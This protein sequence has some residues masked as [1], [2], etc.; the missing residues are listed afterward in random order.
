MT[1]CATIYRPTYWSQAQN[2][3]LLDALCQSN[4]RH[5]FHGTDEALR[6]CLAQGL[7]DTANVFWTL[8]DAGKK[9]T[10]LVALTK[11][12]PP[13]AATFTVF[14]FDRN[15]V[16]KRSLLR[17]LIRHIFADLHYHRL[18]IEMPEHPKLERFCRT[19]LG[20][21]YEGEDTAGPDIA[22][23]GSRTERASFDGSKWCDAIR[24]RLLANE[25]T[26]SPD[27]P[28]EQQAMAAA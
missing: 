18:T 23:L 7:S 4:A 27:T 28:V 25:W 8:Y 2:I 10:G 21:K 12:I 22:R 3:E 9:L 5:L 13:G 14:L 6:L 11:I 26:D 17:K 19:V 16:G 24:L 15:I 1:T 20:A